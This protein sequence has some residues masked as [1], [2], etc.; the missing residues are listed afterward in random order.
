MTELP[1]HQDA[2]N[3]PVFDCHILIEGPNEEGVLSGQVTNLPEIVGEAKSERDL[4]RKLTEAFKARIIEYRD[5]NQTIPWEPGKSP[6]P[7][8]QQRWIP[9]HL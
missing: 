8:Q 9:V 1:I 2:A 7:G 4:L 5:S 6:S 3:V